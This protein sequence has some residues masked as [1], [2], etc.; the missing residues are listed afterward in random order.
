MTQHL[1]S[2]LHL[3]LCQWQELLEQ[4]TNFK[5]CPEGFMGM[6][7]RLSGPGLLSS[8]W[9]YR[10]IL[11]RS[12]AH[13]LSVRGRSF[14]LGLSDLQRKCLF[15]P[16]KLSEPRREQTSLSC[17]RDNNSLARQKK[18]VKSPFYYG[19]LASLKYPP[20]H[21]GRQNGSDESSQKYCWSCGSVFFILAIFRFY[22]HKYDLS[23]FNLKI[24]LGQHRHY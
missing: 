9:R 15:G 14:W 1:P 24:L 2:I 5:K 7:L 4:E 17:Q 10:S 20:K 21:T 8:L 3:P 23:S 11:F 6:V 18:K 19:T 12:L 13:D 22:F 16:K